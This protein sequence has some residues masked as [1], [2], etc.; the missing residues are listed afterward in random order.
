MQTVLQE[1]VAVGK[2]IFAILDQHDA[3][4]DAPDAKTLTV[5]NASLSFNNVIFQYDG[6]EIPALNGVTVEAKP[7]QTIALVGARLG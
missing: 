2:R 7:G 3:I 4:T 5:S 1:G 6:R